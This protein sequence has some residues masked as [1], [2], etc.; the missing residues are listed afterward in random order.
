MKKNYTFID[1]WNLEKT[2]IE[3]KKLHKS[4]LK[5]YKLRNEQLKYKYNQSSNKNHILNKFRDFANEPSNI[6]NPDSFIEKVKKNFAKEKKV[7]IIVKNFD[8]L[9]KKI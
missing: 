3:K 9:K 8:E 6:I 7:K 1:L 4:L 5:G 2:N